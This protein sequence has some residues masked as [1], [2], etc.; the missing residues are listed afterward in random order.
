MFGCSA[1]IAAHPGATVCT[2]FAGIPPATHPLPKWDALCGF[3]NARKAMLQRR[4]EDRA[5]LEIL[6]AQP[7]WLDILDMQYRQGSS[8][9]RVHLELRR[10]LRARAPRVVAIPAGLLH[11]DHEIVHEAAVRLLDSSSACRWVLYEDA[12]YRRADG[13]L[14]ERFAGLR[15][16]GLRVAP[17]RVRTSNRRKKG[18]V[19]CYPSQLRGLGSAG[20]PGYEDVYRE[21]GYW[22]LCA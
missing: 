10:I 15:L 21:E 3:T 4:R 20:P 18:A 2:V 1:L 5:A 7:C 9:A 11:D 12:M 22:T 14:E 6:R 16:R 17:L 8:T 13:V 19:K